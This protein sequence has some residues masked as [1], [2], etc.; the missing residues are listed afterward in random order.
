MG[1]GYRYKCEFC[2][3]EYGISTGTGF[4]FPQ[5]YKRILKD[6]A[7]GKYGKQMKECYEKTPYIAVDAENKNYEGED[8]GHWDGHPVLDLY[9][10]K[11]IGK[12]LKKEFGGKTI[13]ELEEVPYVMPNELKTSYKLILKQEHR[14]PKCKG[15]MKKRNIRNVCCPKCGKKNSPLNSVLWD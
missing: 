8:S 14:C 7:K 13:E 6:V 5:E 4:L 10:P 12:L 1:Y 11:D 2:G 3:K 15:L 9:E